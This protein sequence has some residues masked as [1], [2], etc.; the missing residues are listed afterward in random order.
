M[1][2]PIRFAQRRV[3]LAKEPVV[4]RPAPAIQNGAGGYADWVMLTIL[5]LKERRDETYRANHI[6]RKSSVSG[7]GVFH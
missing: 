7:T 3:S 1:C 4:G 5:C 2:N 6:A